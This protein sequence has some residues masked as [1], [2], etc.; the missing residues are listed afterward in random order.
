MKS[1]VASAI[2]IV[3]TALTP[4]PAAAQAGDAAGDRL[5]APAPSSSRAPLRDFVRTVTFPASSFQQKPVPPQKPPVPLPPPPPAYQ[6]TRE[7]TYVG[8]LDDAIVR[9]RIRIRFEQGFNTDVPDR[10]EFFYA[11]CGCYKADDLLGTD[12]FDPDTPGPGPGV[13]ASLDFQQLYLF[14][15]A[16]SGRL[17]MFGEMPLRWIQA[18][19]VNGDKPFDDGGGL[20]DIRVGMRYGVVAKPG[21]AT[22]I[23]AQFY[24]PSGS[25]E[26]GLGTNHG[27]FEG[28]GLFY[29]ELTPEVSIEGQVGLW[30][31]LGG[32]NPVP[33]AGDGKFSGPV[34]FYG[35]GPS[36]EVY[37]RGNLTV[38]PVVEL[39][40]WNV[41]G[42]FQT[43]P[44]DP[45]AT[46][47]TIA[48]I[49][50]GARVGGVARGS[51]YVGYGK[52]L[53]DSKWYSD[54]F[55]LEYRYTF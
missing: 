48:N 30:I 14:A 9:T 17:S 27:T 46:G 11:K 54:L 23:Q 16:A 50:F 43:G 19:D 51:F 21:Q 52:A 20:S 15:E 53:T 55:R 32:S 25:P 49:K 26:K 28:S 4:D 13:A 24:L 29:R 39:V 2:V 10:A 12:A 22:T 8:Y 37:R 34:L 47:T 44:S 1:V 38:A 3:I 5:L 31:P 45:D 6:P 18:V 40:I 42:G 7:G 36:M 35:V 41:L 33:T